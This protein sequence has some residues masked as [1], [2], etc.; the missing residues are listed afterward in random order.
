MQDTDLSCRIRVAPDAKLI[1]RTTLGSDA[2]WR[3]VMALLSPAAGRLTHDRLFWTPKCLKLSTRGH[4]R[5]RQYQAGKRA[6]WTKDRLSGDYAATVLFGGRKFP[7]SPTFE[8]LAMDASL[9]GS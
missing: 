8:E 3:E 7:E 2:S 4:R 5:G 1:S 9:R 6:L